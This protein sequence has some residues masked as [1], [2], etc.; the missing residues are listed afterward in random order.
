VPEVLLSGDHGRVR[1]FRR[2]EAL[3]ATR[4][5]RPDLLRA[6]AVSAADEALLREA[7]EQRSRRDV[8]VK[9]KVGMKP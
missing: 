6:A 9:E 7:D 5:R 2:Q 1:R 3:L 4:E 8:D